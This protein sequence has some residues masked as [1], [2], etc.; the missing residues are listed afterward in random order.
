M[1]KELKLKPVPEVGKE[2][3]LWDDGKTA[4][5]RHYICRVERV[6]TPKDAMSENIEVTVHDN[7]SNNELVEQYNLYERWREEAYRCNWLF[8]ESTDH[9]VEISCPNYDENNLWCVRTKDGGWFS[10][11]IQ[12]WMQGARLD[13]D[14]ITTE[15]DK[16]I[17]K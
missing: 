17:Q 9:F 11:C 14:G 7:N 15:V 10:I 16:P 8:A 5:S 1:E 13:V 12:N 2:Y 3:H 4:L 6:L